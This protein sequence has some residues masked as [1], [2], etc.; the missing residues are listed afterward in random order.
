[1]K[2]TLE[3]DFGF[4]KQK[5]RI[6]VLKM[7]EGIEAEKKINAFDILG[8]GGKSNPPKAQEEDLL[9]VGGIGNVVEDQP[10]TQKKNSFGFLGKKSS[11]TT[12]QEEDIL[13]IGEPQQQE[14]EQ[15]MNQE[16]NLLD[17]D[18]GGGEAQQPQTQSNDLMGLNIGQE[19][20]V[21]DTGFDL[22]G[23]SIT[24]KPAKKKKADPFGFI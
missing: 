15:Q 16:F 9:G 12:P 2:T 8:G 22:L 19:A 11:S 24:S 7:Q 20:Q 14:Q 4:K 10:K 17:L 21:E 1:M 18:M 13:G 23:G 5:K 3:K 6:N